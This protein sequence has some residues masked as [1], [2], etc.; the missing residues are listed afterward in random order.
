MD[1]R[2]NLKSIFCWFIFVDKIIIVNFVYRLR[3]FGQGPE[4]TPRRKA[5]FG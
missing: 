4:K 2:V 5:G 3:N 1:L